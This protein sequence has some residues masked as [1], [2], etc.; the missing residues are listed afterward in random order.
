MTIFNVLIKCIKCAS[1]EFANDYGQMVRS[2]MFGFINVTIFLIEINFL[3]NR[4]RW[5]F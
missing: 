4:I 1:I 2:S 5:L 3:E